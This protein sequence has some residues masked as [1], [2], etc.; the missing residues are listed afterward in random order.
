MKVPWPCES[1]EAP[2]LFSQRGL[3][4]VLSFPLAVSE[5]REFVAEPWAQSAYTNPRVYFSACSGSIDQL[6]VGQTFEI[7]QAG[8]PDRKLVYDPILE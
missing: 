6:R 4:D 7:C 8:Y 2:F 3:I 5:H 1:R